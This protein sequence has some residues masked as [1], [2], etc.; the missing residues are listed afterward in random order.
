[1]DHPACKKAF[2][3]HKTDVTDYMIC[4]GAE[5][6]DSCN[7]DSGGPLVLNGELVGIVSF[8]IGCARKELPGV[9]TNVAHP[10]IITFI[11]KHVKA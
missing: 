5:N 10:E 11:K 7:G 4:A 8:G 6:T 3:S 2:E 9:Y 1:M